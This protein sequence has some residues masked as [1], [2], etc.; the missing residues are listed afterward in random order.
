MFLLCP[1]LH[2]TFLP[3]TAKITLIIIFCNL[4]MPN[5]SCAVLCMLDAVFGF[6][7]VF[8]SP[9][10]LFCEQVFK[11]IINDCYFNF[12]CLNFPRSKF[13]WFALIFY[14]FQLLC[15]YKV[16]AYKKLHNLVFSYSGTQF[17]IS[18][19]LGLTL[20]NSP[21]Q[22]MKFSIKDFSSKCEQICR[23]LPIGPHLLKKP[24]LENVIFCA[25]VEKKTIEN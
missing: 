5:K 7:V 2:E 21:A 3:L 11:W 1:I 13:S 14:Q 10:S 22:K 19:Y 24:L 9:R 23:K 12:L 18:N 20:K 6:E 16:Y 25:V 15:S 17:F 4:Y 8:I